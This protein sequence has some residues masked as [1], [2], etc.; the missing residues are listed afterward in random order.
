MENG[1]TSSARIP[2]FAIARAA[3]RGSWPVILAGLGV[4]PAALRNRHG[5]CPGCGG[6]DRFRFD[7]RDG[8]GT[9]Y[10]SGGGEPI[11]GDGF[12]LLQHIRG[13]TTAEALHLVA[14]VLGGVNVPPQREVNLP[15]PAG[16]SDAERERLRSRLRRQYRAAAALTAD[17]AAISYL[18]TRGLRLAQYPQ[19]LRDELTHYWLPTDPAPL[20]LGPCAAMLAP[21][22]GS[23][24]RLVGLHRTYIIDGCKANIRHPDTGE[25]LPA[26]KM[27]AAWPG[28]TR[29]GAVRLYPAGPELVVA[30]GI[31]TA[32]A[33]HII[34]GRPAW[35]A[36]SAGGLAA[37]ELPEVTRDVLIAADADEAGERAAHA[38]AARLV[39]EGRVA[40]MAAPTSGGDWLDVLAREVS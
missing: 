12:A 9:F 25:Q 7:D 30:E 6:R 28:S 11:A 19:P 1:V 20:D 31:E 35:A 40:R 17:G 18:S 36:L 39:S 15:E 22:Q 27:R 8:T 13:C 29:G 16:P 33:A 24:D 3:A 32:L 10:C 37:I 23:D 2:S 4:D 14:D 21:I 34:T 38:L 5:P 26:K